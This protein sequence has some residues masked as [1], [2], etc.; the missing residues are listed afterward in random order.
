[1]R[2][3]RIVMLQAHDPLVLLLQL[4][5]ELILRL[6]RRAQTLLQVLQVRLILVGTLIQEGR[7]VA[8]RLTRQLQGKE[9]REDSQLSETPPSHKKIVVFVKVRTSPAIFQVTKSPGDIL[10]LND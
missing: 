9:K 7:V 8:F 6:D 2:Q 3:L 5:D 4:E 1:M 10:T